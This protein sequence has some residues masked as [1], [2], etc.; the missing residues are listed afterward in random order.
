MGFSFHLEAQATTTTDLRG[1]LQRRV[2]HGT[3]LSA[4]PPRTEHAPEIELRQKCSLRARHRDAAVT[5][6]AVILHD[7]GYLEER[8]AH[9]AGYRADDMKVR[10][11]NGIHIQAQLGRH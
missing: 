8:V 4:S 3:K 11:D 9:S 1:G 2:G 7:E 5:S 10:D 6:S